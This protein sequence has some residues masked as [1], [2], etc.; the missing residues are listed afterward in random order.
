MKRRKIITLSS[1]LMLCLSFTF[2]YHPARAVMPWIVQFE[3]T[4]T[5]GFECG[6]CYWCSTEYPPHCGL[7]DVSTTL[8]EIVNGT[9]CD[10]TGSFHIM[11]GSGTLTVALYVDG[12]LRDL[13]ST[14]IPYPD[15]EVYLSYSE[16]SPILTIIFVPVGIIIAVI[17][18]F[19]VAYRHLKQKQNRSPSNT[20][21]A[22]PASNTPA[23]VSILSPKQFCVFCGKE[24]PHDAMFCKYCGKQQRS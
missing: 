4:D 12:I 5:T 15:G 10:E 8:T 9:F 18:I 17:I 20:V 21:A 24:L 1:L 2:S 3:I 13:G 11:G 6:Y 14:S 16:Y 22:I 23:P 7:S 19:Y